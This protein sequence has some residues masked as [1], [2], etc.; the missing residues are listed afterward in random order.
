MAF[1]TGTHPTTRMC[2][3]WIAAHEAD[4]RGERVLDYGCGS[5]ILAIGA[6]LHGG[7]QID[8]VDIDPA[9]ISTTAQNA[10][11]NG[12][13]LNSGAPDIARP[14]IRWCWPTSSPRR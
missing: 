10:A 7:A 2:L 12:V 9:A 8:A 5:G 14:S 6:A 1:G 13:T 3:G 4:M 11:A